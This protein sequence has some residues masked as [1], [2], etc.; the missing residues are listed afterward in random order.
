MA[1]KP[2]TEAKDAFFLFK[3]YLFFIYFIYL[4]AL[5]LSCGM[6]DLVS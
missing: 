1:P 4:S 3:I 5:G 6:W 2:R